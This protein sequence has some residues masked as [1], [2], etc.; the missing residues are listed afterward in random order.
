MVTGTLGVLQGFLP[1]IRQGRD[2]KILVVSSVLGSIDQSVNLPGLADSY[3]VVRA[4]LNMLVRKWG[5]VLKSE[6]ITTVLIHPG[7]ILQTRL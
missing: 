7:M 1:L 4:A 6:G 2:K 3:S 5:G